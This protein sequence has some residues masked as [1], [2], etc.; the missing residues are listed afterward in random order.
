M[1]LFSVPHFVFLLTSVIWRQR[2]YC[3]IVIEEAGGKY[4]YQLHKLC[5][6][7]NFPLPCRSKSII[8]TKP[9]LF[10]E[11]NEMGKGNTEMVWVWSLWGFFRL[12]NLSGR[13]LF[14]DLGEKQLD[15]HEKLE[16]DVSESKDGGN[17]VI[18]L[19]LKMRVVP[20]CLLLAVLVT[21]LCW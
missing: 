3:L 19:P 17:K 4:F 7:L 9:Q 18:L 5:A 2:A 6:D 1:T 8:A 10:K 11:K 13:H 21:G 15:K 12:V 14:P 16:S 20:C